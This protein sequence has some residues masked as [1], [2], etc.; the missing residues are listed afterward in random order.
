MVVLVD[1]SSVHDSLP[2]VSAAIFQSPS[3]AARRFI[4]DLQPASRRSGTAQARRCN[5]AREFLRLLCDSIVHKVAHAI[6]EL[7]DIG[8][9][10]SRGGAARGA[11]P[12]HGG[13]PRIWHG[14]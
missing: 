5:R 14:Q 11:P 7:V 1:S 6:V 8:S 12:S 3:T 9:R 4:F 2:L 13:C 10:L